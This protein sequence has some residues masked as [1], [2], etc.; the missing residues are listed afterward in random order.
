M[1]VQNAND[2]FG[3]IDVDKVRCLNELNNKSGK[4]LFRDHE[5]RFEKDEFV[6]SDCDT[7][8][9]SFIKLTPCIARTR[10]CCDVDRWINHI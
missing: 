8:F 1:G 4:G 5:K 10:K 2:L 7:S 3:S 9:W 6:T